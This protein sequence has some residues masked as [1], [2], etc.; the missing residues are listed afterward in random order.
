[1]LP[2]AVLLAVDDALIR[3]ALEKELSTYGVEVHKVK[4]DTAS[5]TRVHWA[6]CGM[7]FLDVAVTG[8]DGLARLKAIREASPDT[9]VVV[10]GCDTDPVV[11]RAAFDRGAWQFVDKP[12]E[13]QDVIGSVRSEFGAY[14]RRRR[15]RRYLCRLPLRVSILAPES[16]APVELA[17]L[18]CKT[19]DVG[20]GGMRVLTCYQLRVGQRLRSRVLRPADPCAAH[21]PLDAVA[22]VVWLSTTRSGLT[23]GLRWLPAPNPGRTS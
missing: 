12:F 11:K 16:G 3:W 23:G 2:Q 1:M 14:T 6:D 20:P 17:T 5:L 8:R 9:K 7:V 15:H 13:L 19:V 21:V 22:E 18:S 4:T 10:L